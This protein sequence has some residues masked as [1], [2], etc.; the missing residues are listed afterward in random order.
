MNIPL[1]SY[2]QKS[3]LNRSP[4]LLLLGGV[5]AGKSH[6]GALWVISKVVEFPKC[7]IIIAANT[8]SQLMNASVATLIAT[9]EEIGIHYKA[10]LSGARKR[11][12]IGNATIYL[13][14]LDKPDNIRGIE[15]SFSW[16]DEVAF[17]TLKALDVVRGRMRGKHSTY[18]QIFMTSSGNGFNFLYDI[19][20]N[21]KEDNEKKQIIRAKTIENIYL[22]DGYYD[23]LVENYGGLDSPLAKQELLAQ[24]TNLNEG[25]IYNMFD[26]KFNIKKSTLNKQYPVYVGMDFN[27]EKMSAVY[28]QFI[29]GVIH[30]CEEVQLTHR[31][32]NTFDMAAKINKDLQ[33]YQLQIIPDSTGRARKTS[34]S[35]GQTDHQILRDAGLQVMETTNPFI[36]DRQQSVNVAFK[37]SQLI[38]DPSCAQSIKDIETLSSR[39]KEG[40]VSHLGPAL[41]YVV[42]YLM[43]IK[44]LTKKSRT[45]NL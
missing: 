13:Y 15:V 23:Q 1:L 45:I 36:R 32:A 34:S 18:R 31:N 28:C 3:I 10:V 9:L 30:V 14:S 42:W 25:A 5:G 29:G 26:R 27:I 33:G 16:L 4:E 6:C 17:S 19:F 7:E 8:Y 37:K 21:I 44:R 40:K 41:G 39:D 24:F 20:G 11:I 43:P 35:S 38:L 2:Q 12:E 22:P